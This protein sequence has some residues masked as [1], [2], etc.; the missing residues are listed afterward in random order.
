LPAEILRKY[1]FLVHDGWPYLF[2]SF[3]DVGTYLYES[4]NSDWRKYDTIHSLS[5]YFRKFE[6]RPEYTTLDESNIQGYDRTF[7]QISRDIL[8]RIE[9]V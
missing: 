4:N 3:P 1:K 7:G 9:K 5:R 6:R 2:C 8:E